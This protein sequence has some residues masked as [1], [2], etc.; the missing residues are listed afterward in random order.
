MAIAVAT[1]EFE[2]PSAKKSKLSIMHVKALDSFGYSLLISTATDYLHVDCRT[3]IPSS[4]GFTSSL[5]MCCRTKILDKHFLGQHERVTQSSKLGQ[6]LSPPRKLNR[7][8]FLAFL[9][10]FTV[11]VFKNAI[12]FLA[13][14]QAVWL[15]CALWYAR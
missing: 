9:E 8:V 12:A 10:D 15:R 5:L 6:A 2:R 11:F 1:H 4:E 13:P 7:R 14:R 3:T